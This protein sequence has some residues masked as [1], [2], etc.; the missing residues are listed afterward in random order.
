MSVA[1]RNVLL[2]LCT[3]GFFTVGLVACHPAAAT[4]PSATPPIN[5]SSTMTNCE[6][7]RQIIS[8]L[9]LRTWQG[10]PAHCDWQ[11]WTGPL[12]SDWQDV[13]ARPLGS[14]FRPAHQLNVDV[15]GY[16]NPHLYFVEGEAVL[17]EAMVGPHLRS[18]EEL[19][20]ELGAP[21]D[22][23]DWDFGTLPL[24]RSE[25]VYPARGIAL[26]LNTDKDR[27]LHIGLFAPTTLE[28]YLEYIRP[29]FGKKRL[30]LKR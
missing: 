22:K 4:T 15:P 9:D 5:A 27:A 28:I 12:P 19:V 2:L 7:A 30:P 3:G 25:Y 1:L 6:S 23:L 11:A 20:Q 26:F 17:F 18:F 13:Y 29:R 21:A 16:Q 24:P 14:N 10:L 8:S